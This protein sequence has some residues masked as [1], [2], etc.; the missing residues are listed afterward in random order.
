MVDI[1]REKEKE[2]KMDCENSKT[3]RKENLDDSYDIHCD[4]QFKVIMEKQRDIAAEIV[5]NLVGIESCLKKKKVEETLSSLTKLNS[6]V[7]ICE[8]EMKQM[9]ENDA[10]YLE[11]YENEHSDENGD[12]NDDD[13]KPKMEEMFKFFNDMN[14]NIESLPGNSFKKNAR[15]EMKKMIKIASEMKEDR[16][17]EINLKF[18]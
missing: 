9:L 17:S 11:Y 10:R 18:S 14:K 7:Q 15:I 5:E 4:A 6:Q 8:K 3:N 1:T 2:E 16:N 12:S 13:W